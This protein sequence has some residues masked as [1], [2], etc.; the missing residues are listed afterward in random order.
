MDTQTALTSVYTPSDDD[1]RVI[2]A[3]LL[4]QQSEHTRRA[5]RRIAMGL[6][7]FTHKAL[8]AMTL[9]DAQDY[10]NT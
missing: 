4:K 5:Y 6:L 3:W 9:F 10:L 8:P 1:L 7:E 2:G